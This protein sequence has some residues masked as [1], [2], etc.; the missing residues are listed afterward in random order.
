MTCHQTWA[1]P[2]TNKKCC[3]RGPYSFSK[4]CFLKCL[5]FEMSSC[6]QKCRRVF[7]N[8]FPEISLCFLKCCWVLTLRATVLNLSSGNIDKT[9]LIY[10]L[11]KGER[12]FSKVGAS[13]KGQV[14]GFR[15]SLPLRQSLINAFPEV[16]QRRTWPKHIACCS[17]AEMA[18]WACCSYTWI[19]FR[20]FIICV[21]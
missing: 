13:Q 20:E 10:F 6:F 11:K 15:M 7:W 1:S 16:K 18:S 2:I 12:I 21:M 5:F 9:L 3:P 4:L 14:S 8:V 19:Y 17:W